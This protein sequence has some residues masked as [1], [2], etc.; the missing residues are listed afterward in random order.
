[1]KEKHENTSI[2][3]EILEKDLPQLMK[4]T[5]NTKSHWMESAEQRE[6][7]SIYVEPSTAKE[8]KF[9]SL[10]ELLTE[11]CKKFCFFR[12]GKNQ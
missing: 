2:L 9:K 1:M 5:E 12:N 8:A 10:K 4:I 7:W 6:S 11:H 3:G